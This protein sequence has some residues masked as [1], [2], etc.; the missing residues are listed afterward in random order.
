MSSPVAP[1][2]RTPRS[3][4]PIL[5][6][7]RFPSAV[8]L[9]IVLALA[10]CASP[11]G[12]RG[13]ASPSASSPPP[14][15]PMISI[16]QAWGPNA[17]TATFSTQLDATHYMPSFGLAPDG[18]SLDGYLLTQVPPARLATTPAEAGVLDIASHHF[19]P[20]GVASLP[21][22]PGTSCQDTGS[23]IYYLNC[24]QTDGRFLIVQSTGYPGPDCGGCLYAYDQRT[25]RLD[26]IIPA[27]QYQGVSISLLDRGVLVARTGLGLVLVDLATR[28]IKRLS[29]TTGD[30]E[31]DAFS[32]PYLVYGAPDG[33]QHTTTIST[34]LQVY[35]VATGA[36]TALPQVT[37]AILTL[38]GATLYYVATPSNPDGTSAGP[39]TLNVLDNLA[40]PGAQTRTLVTLPAVQGAS[41][42]QSLGVA[43]G[44]L[45]YTVRAFPISQGG[46][47]PGR[48][49][50]CPTA[51][52]AP[53]PVTTL[54]EIDN[55]L[56]SAPTVHAVAAYAADL[57][58][59]AVA[60]A[61]LVVLTGAVWDRAEGR[62]VALGT[63]PVPGSAAPASRQ[64]ATG[65]LLMVAHSLT[66]DWQSPFQV[67]LYDA[68][69]LPVHA[70]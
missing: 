58:D 19:T 62:F 20:I 33:A 47:Q 18:R 4:H 22:C 10:S 43:G 63:L 41:A 37:G 26:K 32:W 40:T 25:G 3:S 51:T 11:S 31:L 9:L 49:H 7:C 28:A 29:G 45:F 1:S 53:P 24:C 8:L 36:S 52:P 5:S 65:N 35:N 61:R 23:A 13:T 30:T 56:A 27:M 57:G 60:N 59:V 12:S 39:A 55:P 66:Q 38:I 17:A 14:F 21:K 64:E 16:T 50:P 2:H 34:P 54:Y 69:R 15:R 70:N 67:S 68:A 6:S 48:N 46:C 44:A 42:P